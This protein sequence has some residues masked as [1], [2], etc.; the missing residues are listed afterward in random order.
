M[1]E[2]AIL[3]PSWK[4]EAGASLIGIVLPNGT[5]AFSKDRIVID[6]AFVEIAR[7]VALRKS[8]SASAALAS[9][10]RACSGRMGSAAS[11]AP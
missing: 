11:S 10:Q 7:Q 1:S 6:E 4:C 3:C 9:A 2:T 5:V 8:D